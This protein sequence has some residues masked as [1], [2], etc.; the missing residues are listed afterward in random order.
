[1][2]IANGEGA[3]SIRTKL[4]DALATGQDAI[5]TGADPVTA[6]RDISVSIIT[7]GGTGGNED[8]I[9]PKFDTPYDDWANP[10]K[11]GTKRIFVLAVHTNPADAVR[12]FPGAVDS[13][14]SCRSVEGHVMKYTDSGVI[15]DYIGASAV[16]VWWDDNWYLFDYLNNTS[17]AW[18]GRPPNIPPVPNNGVDQ[19][20]ALVSTSFNAG[21]SENPLTVNNVRTDLGFHGIVVGFDVNNIYSDGSGGFNSANIA[22]P[23]FDFMIGKR[24][25]IV[26]TS[27]TDP[28]DFVQLFPI[29]GAK[30]KTAEGREVDNIFFRAVDQHLSLIAKNLDEWY[31]DDSVDNTVEVQVTNADKFLTLDRVAEITTGADLTEINPGVVQSPDFIDYGEKKKVILIT[32]SGLGGDQPI[33]LHNYV[34]VID[35]WA[36][37]IL[38]GTR[39]VF[40]VKA[41]TDPSDVV[42]V[43]VG[44]IN[45]EVE[46]KDALG[47]LLGRTIGGAK[48]DYPGATAAFV[49]HDFAWYLEN[50]G[51]NISVDGWTDRISYVPPVPGATNDD[52]ERYVLSV[53][54]G[55]GSTEWTTLYYAD[56]RY[57]VTGSVGFLISVQG[58][59][60][61]ALTSGGTAGLETVGIAA[62]GLQGVGLS[63]LI[64]FASRTNVADE[65]GVSVGNIKNS[66]GS[67]IESITFNFPSQFLLL[68]AYNTTQWR[69][70]DSVEN[71]AVV[72]PA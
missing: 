34:S 62:P 54:G 17:T 52:F 42:R 68:K 27:A 3:G 37:P 55:G 10:T 64:A 19:T 21:W 7:T 46:V 41:Q 11:N 8:I 9:L 14:V 57:I 45:T 32:T 15:L 59:R 1:M 72:V 48:L 39:I 18:L 13:Q 28:A 49:W 23:F 53:T 58:G 56:T 50:Q 5:T 30:I 63:K 22:K 61:C 71:T 20:Y 38:N 35:G 2:T 67:D 69:I 33:L 16:F 4:N 25:R 29:G 65:I 36:N 44:D 70:D 47:N 51:A 66:D 24:L 31:I 6:E 40:T 12:I 43:R 60:Y 26:F